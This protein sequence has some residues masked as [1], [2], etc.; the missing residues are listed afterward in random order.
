MTF[1]HRS[2][3]ESRVTDY[4]EV[5]LSRLIVDV[6]STGDYKTAV[7]LQILKQRATSG[8]TLDLSDIHAY[9]PEL[10]DTLRESLTGS[11]A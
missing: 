6:R 3:Q 4:A 5:A 7:I 2:P 10:A 1:E 9:L 11:L 8:D